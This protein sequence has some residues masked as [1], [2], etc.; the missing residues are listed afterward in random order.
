MASNKYINA[1]EKDEKDL[2]KAIRQTEQDIKSH[3]K[4]IL[5]LMSALESLKLRRS[6]LSAA[7]GQPTTA[8]S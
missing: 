3:R 1:S 6:N 7:R 2:D 8:K 4:Q 5:L